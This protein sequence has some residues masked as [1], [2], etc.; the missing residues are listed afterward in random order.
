[1]NESRLY[2]ISFINKDKV[3][4]VFAKQVYES[5][6][7]GFLAVEGMVFGSASDIVIDP[8]EEKLKAE[9]D[10]VKRSFIPLHSVVRIDEVKERGVCKITDYDEGSNVAVFPSITGTTSNKE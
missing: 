4:D 7:Y 5:D 8:S 6:L 9:F 2:K 10:G 3:Y 1:M